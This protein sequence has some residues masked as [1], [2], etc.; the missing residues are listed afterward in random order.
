MTQEMCPFPLT[1][2]LCMVKLGWGGGVNEHPRLPALSCG[3]ATELPTEMGMQGK[4]KQA[5]QKKKKW[6]TEMLDQVKSGRNPY[7]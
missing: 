5:F 1:L 3:R 7:S 2:V 4:R 6:S